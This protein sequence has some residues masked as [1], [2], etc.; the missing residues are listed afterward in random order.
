MTIDPTPAQPSGERKTLTDRIREMT[1]DIADA[2]SGDPS[3]TITSLG[4]M[5]FECNEL[6]CEAQKI[7]LAKPAPLSPGVA[8]PGAAGAR[9]P[10]GRQAL[11]SSCNRRLRSR[12]RLRAAGSG[13][14]EAE[15]DAEP[16]NEHPHYDRR[17]IAAVDYEL[18][19]RPRPE[20]A[21]MTGEELESLGE[22]IAALKADNVR[23]TQ[24]RD[25]A[26][27]R[28]SLADN[29][30]SVAAQRAT[31]LVAERDAARAE[32]NVELERRYSHE[33]QLVR[34]AKLLDKDARHSKDGTIAGAVEEEFAAE[35]ERREKAESE[36]DGLL[37]S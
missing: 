9:L 36:R 27:E 23:L 4:T 21:E 11:V 5:L 24:E 3:Q 25:A 37:A 13:E 29:T 19:R 2:I 15:G 7:L 33:A 1:G 14:C 28:A 12:R 35:R 31:E 17:A 8:E 10:S 30:A 6:L 16:C 32:R 26:R 18:P 22:A 20:G 34:I